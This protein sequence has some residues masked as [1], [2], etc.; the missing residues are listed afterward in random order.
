VTDITNVGYLSGFTGSL[1]YVFITDSEAI[2]LT[3]GRYTAQAAIQCPNYT[4]AQAKGSGGYTEGLAGILA[5]RPALRRLGYED[6]HVTVS[7]LNHWCRGVDRVIRWSAL[8]GVVESLRA[9][10]DDFEIALIREAV[11]IAEAAL[12]SLLPS[13]KPGI[14]ERDFAIELEFT[15]RRMGADAAAFETIVASGPNGAFPHH[16]PGPRLF[17]AGDL[18]TIDWG[19][20]KDG[21]FSDITR[22][23]AVPGKPVDDTRRTIYRVVDEAKNRAIEACVPGALGRDVDSIARQVI[24]D[25]GY[26]DYFNH[27]LGH[28]LGLSVHDGLTLS[29]RAQDVVLEPGIVT[30]V[31]PGIYVEGVGG[32]RIEEDVL[33][34]NSGPIV[35]TRPA[36]S[37]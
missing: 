7:Q 24:S 3:D 28:G 34:T 20:R 32:V 25:A 18:V 9:I 5:D 36:E 26:G 1:A 29:Q 27:G 19:A 37:L 12:A 15:M 35:L 2:F 17:E 4:L 22:T 31:E 21:Y 30:T 14:A 10:K 8:S 6:E 16:E 33:V 13:I 11:R 23:V